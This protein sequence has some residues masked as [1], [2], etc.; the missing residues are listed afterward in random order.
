MNTPSEI[1]TELA[2]AIS[3]GLGI[4]FTII[5]SPILIALVVQKSDSILTFSVAFYCFS[6]LLMFTFSTLY[7]AFANPLV[8][9]TLRIFDHISIFF[10]IGGTYAPFI[11]LFT[12]S[13]TA[14]WFFIIQ[15][16]LIALGVLKKIFYTGKFRLLSTLI[17]IFIGCLVFFID[18][19][20]W[21]QLPNKSIYFLIAGGLS[22]L[23]GVIFY[24]NQKIP[25][26]HF[27]WHLFVFF[28]AIFHYFGILV[29]I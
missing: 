10:L 13:N 23:I 16:S 20:F 2:N 18:S 5:A 24:Q 17:Y 25:Y 22:Y 8:K 15:W 4:L 11:I 12:P 26:N 3:H 7:H 6:L 21:T 9:K 19:D 29:A 14:F 27:I 1:K 28:A